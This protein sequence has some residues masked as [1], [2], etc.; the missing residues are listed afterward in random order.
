MPHYYKLGLKLSKFE[1]LTKRATK[2]IEDFFIK[3]KNK[4]MFDVHSDINK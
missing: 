2:E 3:I 1:M 4:P